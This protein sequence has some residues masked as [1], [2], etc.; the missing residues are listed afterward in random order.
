MKY[1]SLQLKEKN[2]KKFS[3]VREGQALEGFVVHFRGKFYAYLNLCRHMTLPLD[4]GDEDFFTEDKKFVICRNH[5]AV[6]KPATGLCVAGPCAGLSLE[7]LQ[8]EQKDG[9]IYIQ[10]EA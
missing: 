8:V 6:Y 3:F 9:K 2:S 1:I 4:W 7:K 10:P 5:G